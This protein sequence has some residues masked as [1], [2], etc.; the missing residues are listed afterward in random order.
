[1]VAEVQ[2]FLSLLPCNGHQAQKWKPKGMLL[3]F[4][5]TNIMEVE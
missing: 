4:C 5:H 2:S 3:F 1:M